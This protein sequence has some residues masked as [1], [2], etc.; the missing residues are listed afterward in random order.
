MLAKNNQ[1]TAIAQIINPYLDRNLKSSKEMDDENLAAIGFE[2]FKYDS[3]ADQGTFMRSILVEFVPI[4]F[5]F[6]QKPWENKSD[7]YDD[8]MDMI[9]K[10]FIQYYEADIEEWFEVIRNSRREDNEYY[11]SD[12]EDWRN[13]DNRERAADLYSMI[14]NK[15]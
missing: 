7:C 5:R 4:L 13:M 12:E 8:V 10:L 3:P 15:E 1:A 2:I 14:Q 11:K 6:F 9:Q